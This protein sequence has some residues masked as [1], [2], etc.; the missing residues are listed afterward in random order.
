MSPSLFR[1]IPEVRPA[2]GASRFTGIPLSIAVHVFVVLAIVVI[3]LLATDVLPLPGRQV[4][5]VPMVTPPALPPPARTATRA[6]TVPAASAGAAPVVAPV[7]IRPDDGLTREMPPEETG[8][9]R[10]V[11]DGDVMDGAGFAPIADAPPPPPVLVPVRPGGL[12]REPRKIRHVNPTYP[13]VAQRARVEGVVI[14][15]A[16]ISP[17]GEVQE[18]RVLRSQPLLDEAALSAVRQWRFTPTLLNGIPVPVAI[19]VTVTFTLR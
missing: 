16:I 12:I 9:R 4:E 2:R 3:P 8:L 14:I 7:G 10:G 11:I 19:T 5:W 18:A 1:P 15:E 17:A 6:A 13:D